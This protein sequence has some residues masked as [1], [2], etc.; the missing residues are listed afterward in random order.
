MSSWEVTSGGGEV[1]ALGVEL[2]SKFTVSM[3]NLGASQA[4]RSPAV[5]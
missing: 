1:M 3:V 5:L 2:A 4:P